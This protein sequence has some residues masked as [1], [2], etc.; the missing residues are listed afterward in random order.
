MQETMQN[1]LDLDTFPIVHRHSDAYGE[2]VSRCQAEL[3]DTGMFNLEG[4]VKA[5]ACKAAVQE[6]AP[7]MRDHSFTHRRS[8]NIYFLDTVPGLDPG[9][10]ALNKVETINHTVCA[11]QMSGMII[12]RIYEFPSLLEFLADVM[13][14]EQLY[15]MDDPLARVNVMA[16]RQ[17][18][19]LNWHFDRS[20]FTTTLLLQSPES[21]GE[22][23]YRSG[24]RGDDDPNYQGVAKLLDGTDPDKQKLNLSPGTLN[25]FRGKNTAHRVT[26]VQ[27]KTERMIAV[28]SYYDF[29]G[30]IFSENERI[31]FY[32]RPA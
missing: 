25:I 30:K 1:I 7:V 18:E 16:Y 2:L 10:P 24:L 31:G 29:P 6:I 12:H 11:D 26:A 5:D 21:G 15:L 9:H 14:K 20:E 3:R 23:E 17:G 22:F 8:H 19:A 13:A 32:G 28:F 27:G 4:F